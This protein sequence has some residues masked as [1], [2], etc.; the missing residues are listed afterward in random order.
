MA[1]WEERIR[2]VGHHMEETALT[3]VTRPYEDWDFYS[4]ASSV[5]NQGIDEICST[6]E[7][8]K[9]RPIKP[10]CRGCGVLYAQKRRRLAGMTR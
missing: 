5:R 7:R 3:V 9:T 4:V 2:H 6:I 8:T 10:T 1:E